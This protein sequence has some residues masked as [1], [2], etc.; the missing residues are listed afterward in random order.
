MKEG[1]ADEGRRDRRRRRVS[2]WAWV[3]FVMALIAGLVPARADARVGW[4]STVSESYIGNDLAPWPGAAVCSH[5]DVGPGVGCVGLGR[6]RGDVIS[7]SIEDGSRLPVGALA[8]IRD[9]SG[10]V[11]SRRVFCGTSGPMPAVPGWLVVNLRVQTGYSLTC[12]SKV[13]ALATKGRVVAT[14]TATG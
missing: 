8:E 4:T 1:K 14:F 6:T 12:P 9:G 11:L 7:L 13:P 10:H 3:V 2:T 5:N